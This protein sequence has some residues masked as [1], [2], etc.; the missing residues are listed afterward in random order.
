MSTNNQTTKKKTS[1]KCTI[2][3]HHVYNEDIIKKEKHGFHWKNEYAKATRQNAQNQIQ[4]YSEWDPESD[5]ISN[6]DGTTNPQMHEERI[7][8]LESTV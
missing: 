7:N 8:Y 6:S 1:E 5:L 2:S 4:I 3:H